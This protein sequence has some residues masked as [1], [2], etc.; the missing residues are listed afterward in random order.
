MVHLASLFILLLLCAVLPGLFS[1]KMEGAKSREINWVR[2]EEINSH[3]DAEIINAREDNYDLQWDER[4]PGET[5]HEVVFYVKNLRRKELEDMLIEISN[6]LSPKYGQYLSH[7]EIQT[8]MQ[9]PEGEEVLRDYILSHGG[10]ITGQ[11]NSI[12]LHATAPIS[13]WESAFNCQFH[14][15]HRGNRGTQ[16]AR[17]KEYFLPDHVAKHV[18]MVMNTVQTPVIMD[19]GPVITAQPLNLTSSEIQ[20]DANTFIKANA[21]DV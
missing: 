12:Q 18:D 17:T 10:R 5:E 4:V 2:M 6:P 3:H 16:V 14:Y 7:D 8:M 11:P 21:L 20:M 19:T 13:A 15:V 1:K 9:N